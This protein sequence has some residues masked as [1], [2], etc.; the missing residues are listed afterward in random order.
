M[1]PYK[2]N[3]VAVDDSQTVLLM[4]QALLVELGLN[5]SEIA[6][7][8]DA[9]LALEHIEQHGADIIF[10]DIE[11]PGISGFEFVKSLLE[12]SKQFVPT[13]FVISANQSSRQI[14]RMKRI[15]A[16]RFIRKPID[17]RHF[18]HFVSKEVSRIK[19]REGR[20]VT[21][22]AAAPVVSGDEPEILKY[23]EIAERIGL[24]VKYIPRLMESFISESI[25]QLGKIEAAL[26]VRDYEAVATSSHSIKGS[27]GN[28]KFD[29]VYEAAKAMETASTGKDVTFDYEACYRS[30]KQDVEKIAASFNSA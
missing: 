30:M 11:M 18:K 24:D 7:F 20:P 4:L 2:M 28:M 29:D 12:R 19:H 21:G 22:S 10:T 3:I 23:E 8:E 25:R 14:D 26:E 1:V 16:K 15:G 5:E 6:L 27:A 13:L 17:A 9:G